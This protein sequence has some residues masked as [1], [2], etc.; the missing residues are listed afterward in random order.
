MNDAEKTELRAFVNR[1]FDE[2]KAR[3]QIG[4]AAAYEHY[5]RTKLVDEAEDMQRKAFAA[6]AAETSDATIKAAWE[7]RAK[8]DG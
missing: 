4:I 3:E 5:A 8:K 7:N 2:A 1:I 6:Y